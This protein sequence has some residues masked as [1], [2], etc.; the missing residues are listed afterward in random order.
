MTPDEIR[1]EIFKVRAELLRAPNAIRDLEVAAETCDL[2]ADK[3]FD[4]AL[5]ESTGPVE[6]R[7]AKARLACADARADA[8]IARASYNRAKTKLRQ[9]EVELMALQSVLKSVQME[10]A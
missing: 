7:K 5:L 2:D 9:L 6:E 4:L 1:T 8:V 10:G 3:L